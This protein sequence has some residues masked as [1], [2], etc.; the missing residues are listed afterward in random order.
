MPPDL[1][2][3]WQW[4]GK[5]SLGQSS[6]R[7]ILDSRPHCICR[8][9]VLDIET[10][11]QTTDKSL[12]NRPTVSHTCYSGIHPN[13][14]TDDEFTQWM[15]NVWLPALVHTYPENQNCLPA[16]ANDIRALEAADSVSQHNLRADK[17]ETLWEDIQQRLACTINGKF[18]SAQ[19]LVVSKELE[20]LTK[21]HTWDGMRERF[22]YYW[23]QAINS[24][25]LVDRFISLGKEVVVPGWVTEKGKEDTKIPLTLNWRKCCLG[26]FSTWLQQAD[27]SLHHFKRTHLPKATPRND[28]ETSANGDGVEDLITD[29]IP[30]K[31]SRGSVSRS[32]VHGD[33]AYG[34]GLNPLPWRAEFYPLSLLQD[35]GSLTLEPHQQSSLQQ[36]GLLYCKLYNKSQEIFSAG[37]EGFDPSSLD[38]TLVRAW[39][40][41]GGATGRQPLSALETYLRLRQRCVTA[42]RVSQGKSFGTRELYCMTGCLFDALDRVM[43]DRGLSSRQLCTPMASRQPFFSHRTSLFLDV[44]TWNINR[45]CLGIEL[46]HSLQHHSLLRWEHAQAMMM[47]LQC[48]IHTYGDQGSHLR[49]CKGLWLDR[50]VFPP[51]N[52]SLIR[53]VDEGMGLGKT[54][55][56]SGFGWFLDKLDWNSMLFAASYRTRM[57]FPMP[58]L[59]MRDV[60]GYHRLATFSSEFALTQDLFTALEMYRL[61]TYRSALLLELA[62][63]LCLARFRKDVFKTLYARCPNAFQHHQIVAALQGRVPLTRNGMLQVLHSTGLEQ[64]LEFVDEASA[65][66]GHIEVL[67]AWLWGW[68]EDGNNGSWERAGWK[69]KPFRLLAQQCFHVIARVHN[70]AQAR[71]WRTNLKH[72]FIRTHYILPYPCLNDFWARSAND[73]R[74]KTWA[75][76][77]PLL[78]LYFQEAH[79]ALTP[80]RIE[81]SAAKDLPV[82]GWVYKQI[83]IELDITLEPLP[84]RL[85]DWLS[86]ISEEPL[87][88]TQS[89]QIPFPVTGVQDGPIR[90]FMANKSPLQQVLRSLH[91]RVSSAIASP[92]SEVTKLLTEHLHIGFQTLSDACDHQVRTLELPVHAY[93]PHLWDLSDLPQDTNGNNNAVSAVLEEDSDSESIGSKRQKLAQQRQCIAAK[94]RA[95]EA[96][97]HQYQ[98]H[99]EIVKRIEACPADQQ[100][101]DQMRTCCNAQRRRDRTK[102]KLQRAFQELIDIARGL[103]SSSG[104]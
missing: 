76:S 30:R 88:D 101:A 38:P 60:P 59:Q 10:R 36:N 104:M 65:T 83:P 85:Q 52:G 84:T 103:P 61:D 70:L 32:S 66:V 20:S 50:Q 49:R 82:T 100:S 15:N 14:L 23:D 11:I 95:I 28:D 22:C 67:F 90:Q 42:L 35:C 92:S 18:K 63:R 31:T 68:P 91:R 58:E 55:M 47:F 96:Y 87:Q 3:A 4:L 77:H 7:L 57:A 39:Q 99:H 24:H 1:L 80:P 74:L 34:D 33:I 37:D 53:Y 62:V 102:Q 79:D 64:T 6:V 48:L 51:M 12:V 27:Y 40:Y 45:L 41:F 19:L 5:V 56:Q 75:S 25:F 8:I 17:L 78:D 54:L 44:L 72:A 89:S 94:Q 71:A 16:T 29:G 2:R 86:S 46:V 43:L 73:G 81:L 26:Q 13:R 21:H 93:R 97:I 98:H 9:G 69:Y